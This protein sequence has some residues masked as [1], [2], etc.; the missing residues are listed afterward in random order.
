[1]DKAT[2]TRE[3]LW[4][5][6]LPQQSASSTREHPWIKVTSTREAQC[7]S[8]TREH[9]WIKQLPQRRQPNIRTAIED[10]YIISKDSHM[11]GTHRMLWDKHHRGEGMM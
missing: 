5:K 9:Q 2:S 10:G 7:T 3:P 8:S 1:V 11:S 4:I 6:K